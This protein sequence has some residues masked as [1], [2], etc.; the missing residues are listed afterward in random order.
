GVVRDV[1]ERGY[2]PP[3]KPGIYLS[4]AQVPTTWAVPEDLIVRTAGDPLAIA[5]A[6]RQAIA[7]ID[8]Q[9]PVSLVRT[10]DD[11]IE[12]DVASRHQQATLM[13]TFAALALLLASLGLYG[14]LSYVVTN[15]SREIG[16]RIALGAT[17]ANVLRLVVRRGA[18]LT[19][20]GISIGTAGAWATAGLMRKLLYGV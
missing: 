14:V 12:L 10:M 4:Y 6:A 2:E 18:A 3:H 8:P 20:V 1:R 17:R 19:A 15:R 13:T 16:L 11:I 7:A 5:P 9:Q